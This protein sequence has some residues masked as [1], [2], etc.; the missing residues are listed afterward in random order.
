MGRPKLP[1]ERGNSTF[2]LEEMDNQSDPEEV[3]FTVLNTP[4]AS[5]SANTSNLAH[6]Q[7]KSYSN[8]NNKSSLVVSFPFPFVSHE[9]FSFF[10]S[11]AIRFFNGIT[12]SNVRI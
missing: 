6:R 12:F 11:S 3:P 9:R 10:K 4:L 8:F 2:D 1:L 7:H 5:G